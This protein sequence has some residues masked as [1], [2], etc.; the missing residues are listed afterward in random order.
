MTDHH[1]QHPANESADLQPRLWSAC[2][3]SSLR[4][5]I[6]SRLKFHPLRI[7]ALCDWRENL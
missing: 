5:G 2:Q 1:R 3:V 4:C 7:Y 6:I